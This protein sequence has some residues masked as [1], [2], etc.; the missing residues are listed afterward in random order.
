MKF[1]AWSKTRLGWGVKRITSR[2]EAHTDDPEVDY[3][4]GPLPWKFIREFL[5]RDEGAVCPRQ[6]QNVINRLQRTIVPDD[7]MFYVH[8]LTEEALEKYKM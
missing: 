5:W 1:N 2:R 3:V 8:V 4:V 6:L 7:K